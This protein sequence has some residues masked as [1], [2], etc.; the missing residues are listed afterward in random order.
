ML[1]RDV[2]VKLLSGELERDATAERDGVEVTFRDK[3]LRIVL[4]IVTVTS[5][6]SDRVDQSDGVFVGRGV[7]V[8]LGLEVPLDEK[9]NRVVKEASLEAV[10]EKEIP[11]DRDL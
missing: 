9:V 8:K 6:D 2:R 1:V 4:D 10:L 11:L 7:A 5:G 3:V